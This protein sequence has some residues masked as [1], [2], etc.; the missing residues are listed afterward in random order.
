[1]KSFL[2]V[3]EGGSELVWFKGWFKAAN[4]AFW[5]TLEVPADG[6]NHSKEGQSH[7]REYYTKLMQSGDTKLPHNTKSC[8]CVGVG[9]AHIRIVN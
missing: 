1:M 2:C 6:K 5:H 8:L 3:G 4:D 9:G 7:D